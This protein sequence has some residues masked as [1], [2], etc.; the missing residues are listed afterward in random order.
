MRNTTYPV[1]MAVNG[2]EVRLQVDPEETL[3]EMLRDR[4]GLTGAKEACGK[5][6][7]GTC[8]VLMGGKAVNSCLV[9]ALQADGEEILTIEGMGEAGNLHPIQKAFVQFNA[10]QCGYCTS[11]MILSVKA[12]LDSNPHPTREEIQH[13]LSGNLC[14]CTGY[15][16]IIQAVEWLSKNGQA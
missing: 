7:C 3:L 11:G 1:R 5:G 15:L 16:P 13:G 12:L 10:A 14:R 2:R 6:D 9:L 4:L 8:T